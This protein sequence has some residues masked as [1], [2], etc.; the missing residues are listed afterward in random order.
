MMAAWAAVS[1]AAKELTPRESLLPC[2]RARE[3]WLGFGEGSC[4]RRSDERDGPRGAEE[5]DGEAGERVRV[6]RDAPAERWEPLP[7]SEGRPA[8]G[9]AGA[10]T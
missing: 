7:P 4:M 9:A 10:A 6:E 1:I 3:A 8:G 5:R 2:L